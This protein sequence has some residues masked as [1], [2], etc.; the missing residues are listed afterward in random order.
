VCVWWWEGEGE[1]YDLL[2]RYKYFSDHEKD[3]A[4][5]HSV[6]YKTSPYNHPERGF[7]FNSRPVNVEFIF[8]NVAEEQIFSC[9]YYFT[10]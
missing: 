8:E 9:H 3:Y 6:Y 5:C 4:W 2:V 7:D 1:E 10:K